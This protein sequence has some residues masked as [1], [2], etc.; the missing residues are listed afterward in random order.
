MIV[1]MLKGNTVSVLHLNEIRLDVTNVDEVYEYLQKGLNKASC[2]I[3][4]LNKLSYMDS[5]GLGMLLNCY[6]EV[7]AAGNELRIVTDSPL[8][9]ALFELVYLEKIVGVYKT[10]TEA[11]KIKPE[12]FEKVL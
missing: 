5:S 10:L 1:E 2:I 8:V 3:I 6:R 9:L 4:D 7:K 11:I 12:S